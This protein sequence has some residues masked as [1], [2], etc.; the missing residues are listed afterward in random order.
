[1]A[2]MG[3]SKEKILQA[4]RELVLR[5]GWQALNIRTVAAAC[6]ISVGSVYNCFGSKA[7]L[8][9]AT[10]ESVWA[11]I[12]RRP[13]D[14]A[15]VEDALAY[16]AWSYRCLA[17]G[18]QRYPG[19]FSLH[20]VALLGDD[21]DEGRRRMQ[22]AWQQIRGQLCTVLQH[23]PRVRPD[24]FGEQLPAERFAGLLF[25]LLLAALVQGDHDPT[26][27][28]EVVRRTLY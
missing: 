3:V 13:S 17:D 7:E 26:A 23:D 15:V 6:Q 21:R 2:A 28:L 12:F 22:Q 24:A 9:A 27:V 16:V 5:Q 20:S 19:F 8:V 18:A 4:S 14:P 25:S 11:D 1:M 10:V